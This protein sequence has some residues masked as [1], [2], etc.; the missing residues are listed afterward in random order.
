MPSH[1]TRN[2]LKQEKFNCYQC[3]FTFARIKLVL[4]THE[5]K[6]LQSLCGVKRMKRC[7]SATSGGVTGKTRDRAQERR[8]KFGVDNPYSQDRPASVNE[9]IPK[10]NKGRKMLEKSGWKDG[11]G[12]GKNKQGITEPI[13][14]KTTR[15]PR[16]QTGIGST[17]HVTHGSNSGGAKDAKRDKIKQMTIN[18]YYSIPDP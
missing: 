7:D 14:E 9:S 1:M 10:S 8:N 6:T 11:E 17:S 2:G 5:K 18:R 3:N 16:D 13:K 15:K 12:L 4:C